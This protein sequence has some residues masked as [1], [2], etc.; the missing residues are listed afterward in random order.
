MTFYNFRYLFFNLFSPKTILSSMDGLEVEPADSQDHSN[1]QSLKPC[2]NPQK[3][4]SVEF[5]KSKA[6]DGQIEVREGY[7]AYYN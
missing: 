2:L 3:L 5:I 4:K 6:K 7:F 1:T